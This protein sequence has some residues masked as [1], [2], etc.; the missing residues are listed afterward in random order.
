VNKVR[1]EYCGRALSPEVWQCPGCGAPVEH[2]KE[3]ETQEPKQQTQKEQDQSKYTNHS[4]QNTNGTNFN[5]YY[6]QYEKKDQGRPLHI[7]AYGSFWVRLVA[8]CI[9]IMIISAVCTLLGATED[10]MALIYCAYYIICESSIGNGATIGKKVMGLKVVNSDFET[11]SIG[12]SIGRTLGKFL[13]WLLLGYGFFMILISKRRQ[14]LHDRM[15]GTY[16]IKTRR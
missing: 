16:V 3:K 10:L 5:K 7:S 6:E 2:H 12:Q 11:I 4:N 1:C 9:D 14:G 13:S 8:D 15:S